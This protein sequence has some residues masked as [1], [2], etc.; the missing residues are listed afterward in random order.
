M[1]FGDVE[2]ESVC[3]YYSGRHSAESN[4]VPGPPCAADAAQILFTGLKICWNCFLSFFPFYDKWFSVG[5][6]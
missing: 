2:V 5:L 1:F 6:V 3:V 4:Q